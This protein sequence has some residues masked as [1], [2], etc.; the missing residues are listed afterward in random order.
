MPQHVRKAIVPALLNKGLTATGE[1]APSSPL[2]DTAGVSEAAMH[3]FVL[4]VIAK[5]PNK[6]D[7]AIDALVWVKS[8]VPAEAQTTARAFAERQGWIVRSI[9]WAH[10]P[11]QADLRQMSVIELGARSVALRNGVCG[12]LAAGAH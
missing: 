1:F 12:Y 5:A 7:A 3:L 9:R 6:S 11:T 2:A 8:L 4:E 10:V